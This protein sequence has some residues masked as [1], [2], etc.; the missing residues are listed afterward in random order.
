VL[1]LYTD[2]SP[3]H[4]TRGAPSIPS[5]SGRPAGPAWQPAHLLASIEADLGEYVPPDALADDMAMVAVRR[6]EAAAPATT[7]GAGLPVNERS[8]S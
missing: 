3:R 5:R 1:L 7:P 6:E 2:G 4:G 8:P